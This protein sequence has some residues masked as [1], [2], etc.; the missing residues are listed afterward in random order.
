MGRERLAIVVCLLSACGPAPREPATA[1]AP[2][3]PRPTETSRPTARVLVGACYA[4]DESEPA[5]TPPA[6]PAPSAAAEAEQPED[7]VRER[8]P[9]SRR[10]VHLPRVRPGRQL[11]KG[12][13]DVDIIRRVIRRSLPRFRYCYEKQLLGDPQLA[14]KVSTRFVIDPNGN[15]SSATVT[16]L[17]REV[18]K[19]IE[20]ALRALKFPKPRG[21]GVVVVSYPF[22]F[23][24]GGG[25]RV[26]DSPPPL[27]DPFGEP[28]PQAQSRQCVPAATPRSLT[29]RE[30]ILSD[31]F[32]PG[33]RHG[34][35][36]TAVFSFDGS[37][38]VSGVEIDGLRGLPAEACVRNALRGVELAAADSGAS[39]RRE[40][41]CSFVLDNPEAPA[42]VSRAD[43]LRVSL[44]EV[45]FRGAPVADTYALSRDRSEQWYLADLARLVRSRTGGRLAIEAHPAVDA[46]VIERLSRT[47]AAV[48][49]HPLGYARE[50]G[51][52]GAWMVVNPLG[53]PD[54]GCQGA[55]A[56]VSVR[57]GADA[58][59]VAGPDHAEH[60]PSRAGEH[61][62][63]RM[64]EVLA[65]LRAAAP[66]DA[67]R[68]LDLSASRGVEYRV[69]LRAVEL[70]VE[71]GFFDTRVV[72][73]EP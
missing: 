12:A 65:R 40:L 59:E 51:T 18:A 58:I 44:S 54:W 48:G 24:P 26:T 27:R 28:P 2:P 72:A 57:I 14:G 73:W 8:M 35:R 20:Q 37:G 45:V 62:F 39:A 30:E 31:C 55:R 46:V 67:R 64:R 21:G 49:A 9:I 36:W 1:P 17:N 23:Q 4:W 63:E 15:V 52:S 11:V 25:G 43:E 19:C 6:A 56:S 3:A 41:A 13:L 22:V 29:A 69:L 5:A 53:T 16:G 10:P 38:A 47:L 42:V 60:I 7:A 34:E 61:D 33:H 32:S 71:A 50:V 70:A 66:G 68:A